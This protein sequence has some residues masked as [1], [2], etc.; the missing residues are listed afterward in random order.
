MTHSFDTNHAKLYGIEAAIV[1]HNMR[2]WIV[3]NIAN[4]N[5][6]FDGNYWTYNSVRA[7]SELFPY[8][9]P[10]TIR[11]TLDKLV[12]VGFLVKGDYNRNPYDKTLWYAFSDYKSICEEC[13]IDLAKSTNGVDKNDNSI[14][15]INHAINKP[16]I[17]HDLPHKSEMFLNAWSDW[18]EFRKQKK[19]TLT[20]KSIKFQLR[21]LG[22]VSES[23]AI[24]MIEQSIKNGWTGIFPV[25]NN[26]Y[27]NKGLDTD[28]ALRNIY[29][30]Q[31]SG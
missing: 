7:W 12:D 28:A 14:T 20:P 6:F 24:A 1:I 19:Q 4:G 25:K 26:Q 18:V 22:Y 15:N 30:N 21:D 9:K 17:I 31:Q 10:S 2:Y 8:M 29:G 16:D 27:G 3:K 23:V 13:H 5:N 11:R